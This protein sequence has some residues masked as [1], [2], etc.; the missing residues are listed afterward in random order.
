MNIFKSY[1]NSI[2]IKDHIK[3]K[4]VI[5]GEYPYYSGY[6]HRKPFED[7]VMYL[8]E[9]KK[10]L[11]KKPEKPNNLNRIVIVRISRSGEAGNMISL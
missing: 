6:D 11:V 9:C 1:R 5:V 7:C 8:D 3:A 4:H 2:I 10:S